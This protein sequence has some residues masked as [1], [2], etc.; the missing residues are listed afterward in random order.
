MLSNVSFAAQRS[1][2]EALKLAER[3]V[4]AKFNVT[5]TMPTYE[6]TLATSNVYGAKSVSGA[7]QPAFYIFNVS[8][9]RGFVVIAADTR[10]K[11]ILGYSTSGNIAD[12]D[13]PESLNYWLSFLAG[14]INSAKAYFDAN[15]ITQKRYSGTDSKVLQNDIA[16][17]IK[18][19]WNQSY[20]Y[21]LMCPEL[22][23]GKGVTGCVA[24]GMAQVMKFHEYPVSGIGSHTN[25][26]HSSC[27]ADF[28]STVYDWANMTNSYDGMSSEAEKKA[29]ATLM[30]HCGVATDMQY[31]NS[32]SSATPNIFAGLAL[33]NYFGYN[34]NLYSE[35]RNQMSLGAW[36]DLLLSELNANRPVM[37][38]GF[39]DENSNVGHFFIC[40][41]YE[42][43]S[44]KFHFNWGWGGAY[45]G[46]YEITALEPGTGGIGAGAGSYNSYQNVIVGVQPEAIGE[47]KSQFEMATFEPVSKVCNQ[48]AP[49]EFR[50]TK[51]THSSINFNGQIGFAVYK[52]GKLFKTLSMTKIP[53]NMVAGSYANE[54]SLSCK[55]GSEF[56][57]GAYQLCMIAQNEG[58]ENFDVIRAH[59]NNVT[60]WNAEVTADYKV[61][62]TPVENSVNIF[63]PSAPVLV[64]NSENKIFRNKETVFEI[65]LTNEGSTEYYDEVG[66][67]VK[68]GRTASNQQYLTKTVRLA[69]GE[70]KTIAVGGIVTLKEDTGYSC[71][72]CYRD[73]DLM[74]NLSNSISVD[75]EPEANGIEFAGNSEKT[76]KSVEYYNVT[77]AKTA[78]PSA[79][80]SIR[81][82]VYT[83]G[84]VKTVK[85]YVR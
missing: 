12:E 69:P 38:S 46:Y 68:K 58:Q 70:T 32:S 37:Y 83:D 18:T 19:N 81:R 31:Q 51:F 11:D 61:M 7:I 55:F 56:A 44:G 72:V 29:V 49:M 67:L 26:Y 53:S 45:D 57:P 5:R 71:M 35:S 54:F 16:P 24:T 64:S 52:E 41:G 6:L 10:F 73:H 84:S 28:A 39:S 8:E 9:N 20:P 3:F 43:A 47:Y 78:V 33:V 50:M 62:F 85:I 1:A 74:T 59:Y 14:E 42:A 63:S 48:G 40:D 36:K 76:V 79:G 65:T 75:V 22:P 60:I 27:S 82:T 66:V 17:L 25:R 21:N 34:P 2:D 15:G 4:A 80:I 23:D 30:Y 13:I 77:G